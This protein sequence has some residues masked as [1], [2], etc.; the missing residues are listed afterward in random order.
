VTKRPDVEGIE[1]DFNLMGAG[2]STGELLE[3]IHVLEAKVS[4]RY[5]PSCHMC[6]QID[7]LIVEGRCWECGA[8]HGHPVLGGESDNFTGVSEPP[9]PAATDEARV[10]LPAE[11]EDES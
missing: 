7:A 10:G 8:V 1:A 11:H 9:G 4:M 6:G 3:W 2:P 5:V